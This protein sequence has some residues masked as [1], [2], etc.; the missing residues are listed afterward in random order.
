VPYR[1]VVKHSDSIGVGAQKMASDFVDLIHEI[2]ARGCPVE[3]VM[4]K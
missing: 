1:L 2:G 4:E 3:I